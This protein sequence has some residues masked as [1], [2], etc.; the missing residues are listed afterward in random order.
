MQSFSNV[1]IYFYFI[2]AMANQ[3]LSKV[4]SK[5]GV[6]RKWQLYFSFHFAIENTQRFLTALSILSFFKLHHVCLLVF[7]VSMCM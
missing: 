6:K 5:Y 2:D 7:Y 1:V 3:D 4:S